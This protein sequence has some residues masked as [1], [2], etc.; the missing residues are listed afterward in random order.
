MTEATWCTCDNIIGYG[1]IIGYGNIIGYSDI[2]GYSNIIGC[3][4]DQQISDVKQELRILKAST[5]IIKAW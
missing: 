1:D 5:R 2:I 4:D 3:G